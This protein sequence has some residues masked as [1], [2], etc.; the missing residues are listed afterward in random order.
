MNS[1]QGNPSHEH[2]RNLHLLSRRGVRDRQLQGENK[3]VHFAQQHDQLRH[4]L[5]VSDESGTEK[6]SSRSRPARH[7][8]PLVL[9]SSA[10]EAGRTHDAGN[11]QDAAAR[12]GIEH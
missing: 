5:G 7:L 9:Q 4:R 8:L 2:S 6:R 11:V 10:P 12:A 3:N 1:F